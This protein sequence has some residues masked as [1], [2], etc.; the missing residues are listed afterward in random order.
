MGLPAFY[1]AAGISARLFDVP[2][3]TIYIGGGNPALLELKSLAAVLSLLWNTFRYSPE[4]EFTV[5]ITPGAA[6]EALLEALHGLGVNRLSIGAQSFNDHELRAVGRLHS[7]EETRQCVATARAAGFANISLDLVGGLPYQTVQSWQ[8]SL[9]EIERLRPE[10]VSVYLLEIDEKSRLGREVQQG[11]KRYHAKAL[12]GE[13]FAVGAYTTA[14]DCLKRL[15][16]QQY[17]ISNFALSSHESRHNQKYW[18]LD[19]YVGLGAGAHSFNGSR[20]WA[21]EREPETY[22]TRLNDGASPIV[23]IR[24]LTPERQVEEF[25]FTRAGVTNCWH[26]GRSL[27]TV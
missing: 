16:Y 25:F 19:P 10:H 8:A 21:N 1:R 5:E 9:G 12:P 2:V 11:G 23:E 27:S 13:D 20:R 14:K 15:G 6:D 18:R 22:D 17:E 4:P 24:A 3:D 26:S 7:A